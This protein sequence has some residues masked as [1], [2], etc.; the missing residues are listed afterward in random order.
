MPHRVPRFLRQLALTRNTRS[1]FAP[2]QALRSS[3]RRPSYLTFV[4]GGPA[5]EML[6]SR[7][8]RRYRTLLLH[9]PMPPCAVCPPSRRAG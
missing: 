9:Q 3:L 4:L 1:H 5:S 8:P 2:R 7:D 6:L